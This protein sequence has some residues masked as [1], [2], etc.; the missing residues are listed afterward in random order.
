MQFYIWSTYISLVCIDFYF[1]LFS[2]IK[3]TNTI[4]MS[5]FFSWLNSENWKNS[6]IFKY[7]FNTDKEMYTIN[8]I[9]LIVAFL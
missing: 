9:R 6:L 1:I 2:G 8:L 4:K 5:A 3:H 7:I